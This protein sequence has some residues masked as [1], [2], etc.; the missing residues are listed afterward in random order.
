MLGIFA[1]SYNCLVDLVWEVGPFISAPLHLS[2][3]LIVHTITH[4]DH[5][6]A[7]HK[8]AVLYL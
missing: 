3:N 4:P 6:V 7:T 1:V 8:L 2:L 5:F